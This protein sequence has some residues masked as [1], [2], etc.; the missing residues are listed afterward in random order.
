MKNPGIPK[1][2]KKSHGKFGSR[3]PK[4]KKEQQE[5]G[6]GKTDIIMCKNCKSVYWEKS[7]HHNLRNYD[8]LSQ[9]KHIK[10]KLC[11]ACQMVRDHKFEGKIVLKNIPP[12]IEE[13][14]LNLI[15][16]IGKR[17]FKR[18]PMDRIINIEHKTTRNDKETIEVFTTENQL[19]VSIGKQIKNA[20]D[21]KS[22]DIKWSDREDT[23]RVIVTFE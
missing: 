16:N 15:S 13:E 5:Y 14:A 22:V 12:K 20:L 18:D 2:Q 7:W 21:P 4:P 1:N 17:A 3:R 19:A 10:F 23:V 6:P 8:Q 9:N 11:P